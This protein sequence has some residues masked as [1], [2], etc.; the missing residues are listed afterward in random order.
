[1]GIICIYF[2][3]IV[4]INFSGTPSFYCTDMYADMQ[5]ATEAWKSKSLFPPDWVFGNQLYVVATPVLAALAYGFLGN[6]LTAM[7]V[8]STV[9]GFLV[10][11]TFSWMVKP[12]VKEREA[13]WLSLV[14][15]LAIVLYFGGAVRQTNGWQLLFTMCSYYACY[16]VTAFL[17]FGCYLRAEEHNSKGFF[18][19]LGI[20]CFLSFGTGIQSLRQTAVMT[21]PIMGMSLLCLIHRIRH[22]E[23]WLNRSLLTSILIS[24][25]NFA[26]VICAHLLS[27]SQKEIFGKVRVCLPKKAED[28]AS[29]FHHIQGLFQT[30]D[31]QKSVV[32]VLLLAAFVTGIGITVY[33]RWKKTQK[34]KLSV[35]LFGLLGF[36]VLAIAAT[37]LL[38]TMNVREIYYFMVYPLLAFGIAKMY[39]C[40]NRYFCRGAVFVLTLVLLIPSFG[41]MKDCCIQAYHREEDPFYM[42]SDYLQEEGYTTVYSG[43]NEGEKVAIASNMEIQA[44]FW[45]VDSY[46]S[47]PYLCNRHIYDTESTKCVYLFVSE[48]RKEHGLAKAQSLGYEL[49]LLKHFSYG[50]IDLYI[51]PVNLMDFP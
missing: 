28:I 22:G 51:A 34:E 33:L 9:Y 20:T 12:A 42:V 46:V 8:A 39:S 25:C 23:K 3:G 30:E 41:G 32:L 44:G 19:V 6:P 49:T 26:G 47:V 5:Y 4:Y 31:W 11:V 17:A 1:M 37:D 40:E 18:W 16:A 36:S 15:L 14:L 13:R 38:T 48:W 7:A 10:L 50:N 43:W 2:L 29:C 24:V 27:V 21:A 35:E 45:D